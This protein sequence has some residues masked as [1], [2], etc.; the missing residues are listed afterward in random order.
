MQSWKIVFAHLFAESMFGIDQDILQ[1]T[2]FF[3]DISEPATHL[4]FGQ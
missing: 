3:A 4:E 1:K 2:R